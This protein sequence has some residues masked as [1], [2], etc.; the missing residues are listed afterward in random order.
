MINFINKF[1]YLF[2]TL[3]FFNNI[4][5][6]DLITLDEIANKKKT[7]DLGSSISIELA[8]SKSAKISSELSAKIKN[9]PFKEGHSFKKNDV[10]LQFECNS[11]KAQLDKAQVLKEQSLKQEKADKQLLELKSIGKV[12]YEKSVAEYEKSVAEFKY[13]QA[14]VD[15]CL[16]NAPF[17]GTVAELKYKELEYVETGKEIMEIMDINSLEIEFF[18]PSN[19]Y[20]KIKVNQEY[21]VNIDETGKIYPAKII[22]LGNKID[23]I[24]KTFKVFAK[25]NNNAD[26]GLLPGMSG[27][28]RL[29]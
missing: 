3:V 27:T 15:K 2:F 28:I 14:L 10:L 19:L 23:S 21:Q 26:A 20:S 22:R 24:S 13:F 11:Q 4:Y 12:E 5:A 25:L 18:A 1:T 6:E 16:I 29:N 9:I 17:N 8:P 7:G